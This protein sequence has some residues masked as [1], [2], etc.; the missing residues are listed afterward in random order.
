MP[1]F[2]PVSQFYCI[3]TLIIK[4]ELNREIDPLDTLLNTLGNVI[5]DLVFGVT[6]ENDDDTWVYLRHLQEEGVKHVGVSGVVNFIPW[7]R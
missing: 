4:S 2:K 7:L 1:W 6:Y 5:N 3:Q